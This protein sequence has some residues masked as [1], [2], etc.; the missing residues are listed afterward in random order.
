MRCQSTR[1]KKRVTRPEEGRLTS[2][3]CESKSP[4]RS[5]TSHH[6]LLDVVPSSTS[7]V[8]VSSDGR[9]MFHLYAEKRRMSPADE[10]ILYDFRGLEAG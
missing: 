10:F 4:H 8:S 7:L 9:E 6:H 2:M 1:R 5:W 3:S